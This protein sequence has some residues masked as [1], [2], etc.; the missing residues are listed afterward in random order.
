MTTK[1]TRFMRQWLAGAIL[2]ITALLLMSVKRAWAVGYDGPEA[3]SSLIGAVRL[4]PESSYVGVPELLEKYIKEK[5]ETAWS[6]IKQKINYT[7]SN[8]AYALEPVLFNRGLKGRILGEVH[9][10]KKLFFKPNLVHP[11]VLSLVGNGS[12]GS[13]TGVVAATDW[14]FVAALMRFFHD[15][16]GI[17]YYQMAVGEA[18]AHVPA[19]SALIGCRPEALMEG[20]PF[21][22]DAGFWAGWPFYF[23]RKCLQE[24]GHDPDDDPMSGYTDSI[25][26]NYVTPGQATTEGKLIV[27]NMNDAEWFG[28]GRLVDV[29]DGGDNYHE[30]II[31]KALI[32]DPAGREN[33][34]GT[35]LVNCPILKVHSITTLTNAI[36]NLGMGGWPMCAG[37]DDDPATYDWKYSYP[38]DVP[39]GLKAGVPGWKE[40]GVWKVPDDFIGGVSYWLRDFE[41]T[42][43]VLVKSYEG[44]YNGLKFWGVFWKDD[45][46]KKR[47]RIYK[48]IEMIIPACPL[49]KENE[50]KSSSKQFFKKILRSGF[51]DIKKILLWK[52]LAISKDT[53][54]ESYDIELL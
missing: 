46:D 16:L 42:I 44:I 20:T 43:S 6:K 32:G 26:G 14:A 18:G 40:D 51:N 48:P 4:I 2:V 8:L 23:V 29:P 13:K 19:F 25:T 39:P 22:V 31:H 9:R 5:D 24:S 12:P 52:T 33:Y 1:T 38:P 7:Y 17:H 30:I 37:H 27:Y 45:K 54:S 28:R 49:L 41:Y 15:K 3:G 47:R 50:V 36:K 35:V 11:E 10:G 21:G 53:L 34:P